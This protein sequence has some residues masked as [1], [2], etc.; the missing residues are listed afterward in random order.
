MKITLSLLLALVFITAPAFAGDEIETQFRESF[1]HLYRFTEANNPSLFQELENARLLG[2]LAAAKIEVVSEKVIIRVNGVEQESVAANN[3]V[4]NTIRINRARWLAIVRQPLREALALHEVAGLKKIESSSSYPLS[5]QYL[6]MFNIQPRNPGDPDSGGLPPFEKNNPDRLWKEA[7]IN[8]DL[9]EVRRR[10]AEG[11]DVNKVVS[12]APALGWAAA[13]GFV[14]LEGILIEAKANPNIPSVL[15]A[16][17]I[18]LAV[19]DGYFYMSQRHDSALYPELLAKLI[20]AGAKLS[21]SDEDGVTP[22]MWAAFYGQEDAVKVFIQAGA[23]LEQRDKKGDNAY[24]HAIR[25]GWRHIA[26]RLAHARK[27]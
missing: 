12:G 1:T 17:P 11:M 3:P 24:R 5:S 4:T 19:T 23:D 18:E 8:N 27:D 7:I 6:A 10:I 22:L 26:E 13:L 2:T 15:G 25:G 9:T 16:Y 20:R 14:E 21:V